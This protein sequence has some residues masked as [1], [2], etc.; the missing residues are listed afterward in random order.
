M[1]TGKIRNAISEGKQKLRITIV[2]GNCNIDNVKFTCTDVDGIDDVTDDDAAT[3]DS[4]GLSGQQV[5][6]GY[7]G[8]VVR[9]GKKV[10]LK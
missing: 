5:G 9:D 6:K 3:G 10:I 1:K 4:Y 2:N 8:I 7:K